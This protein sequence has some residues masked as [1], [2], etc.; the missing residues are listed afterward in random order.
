MGNLQH[1]V[2]NS[3]ADPKRDRSHRGGGWFLRYDQGNEDMVMTLNCPAT[4]CRKMHI[5][6]QTP[7]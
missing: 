7:C 4:N 1:D 5:A 2:R 3:K 6:L